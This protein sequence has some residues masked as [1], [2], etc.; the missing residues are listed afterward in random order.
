M[1]PWILSHSPTPPTGPCR[2]KNRGGPGPPRNFPNMREVGGAVVSYREER[3]VGTRREAYGAARSGETPARDCGRRAQEARAQYED[4]KCTCRHLV[5]Q[6]LPEH[7]AGIRSCRVAAPRVRRHSSPEEL[8]AGTRIIQS[9]RL[10]RVHAALRTA[11]PA[12]V[13]ASSRAPHCSNV[14]PRDQPC[15]RSQLARLINEQR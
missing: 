9:P 10:T 4:N 8:A 7:G 12:T 11:C 6:G 15:C 5:P 14:S 3:P 13:T 1:D 2:I